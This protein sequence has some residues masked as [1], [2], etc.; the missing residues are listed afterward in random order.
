MIKRLFVLLSFAT[1]F[2]VS[3]EKDSGAEGYSDLELEILDL[4]NEHRSSMGKGALE[5]HRFIYDQALSHTSDMI[6][7]EALSHDGFSDRAN[8]IRENIGGGQVAENVA[9][10]Y[11]TASSVVQ[12]W[13]DSNGH[14][15]NIEGNFTLTGIA[16]RKDADGR[17]YYTQIFLQ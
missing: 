4:V 7:V 9:Y 14:R 16:A 3:C 5:M 12:G 15:E 11:S 6:R 2:L 1:L 8:E 17:F 13:L 10:G